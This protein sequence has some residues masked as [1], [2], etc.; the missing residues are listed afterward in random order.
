MRS[1]FQ[2]TIVRNAH[3]NATST[4]VETQTETEQPEQPEQRPICCICQEV[5]LV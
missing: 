1:I 3:P 4:S 5:C 2:A